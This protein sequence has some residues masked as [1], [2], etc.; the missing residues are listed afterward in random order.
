MS[1]RTSRMRLVEAP[2]AAEEFQN[3]SVIGELVESP[4]GD[5]ILQG[6]P[7]SVRLRDGLSAH[8]RTRLLPVG[9]VITITVREVPP[10]EVRV[11]IPDTTE[12]LDW[13]EVAPG[14]TVTVQG[15]YVYTKIENGDGYCWNAY[16]VD[17]NKFM[18]GVQYRRPREPWHLVPVKEG[19]A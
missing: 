10:H 14:E 11:E 16:R 13:N 12:W 18:Q 6:Q 1:K 4:G 15:G 19:T 9:T 17:L 7:G 3:R 2:S 5:I 8:G